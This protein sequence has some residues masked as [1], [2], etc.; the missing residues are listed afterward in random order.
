[1]VAGCGGVKAPPLT[2]V[3]GTIKDV[4]G[5]PLD[6]IKVSFLPDPEQGVLGSPGIGETDASGKFV[7]YYNGDKD[8]PGSAVGSC[9]VILEDI[10][11][12]RTSR[13]PEPTL[14]RFHSK[15]VKANSTDIKL[16]VKDEEGQSFDIVV[17]PSDD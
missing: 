6:G 2:E 1:M 17:D 16:N 4:D 5:N 10:K 14:R 9:F 3:S 8:K 13:D 15:Y 7:L 12:I 11:A